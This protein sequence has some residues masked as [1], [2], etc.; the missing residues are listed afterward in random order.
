M[1]RRRE[2]ID[3]AKEIYFYFKKS[4]EE[5]SINQISKIMKAKYEITIK[6]LEFLKDVGLLKERKGTSKPISERLFSLK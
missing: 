2:A 4:K 1:K 5:H 3:V 6:S